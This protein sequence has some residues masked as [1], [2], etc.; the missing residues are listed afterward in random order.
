MIGRECLMK[1]LQALRVI[2]IAALL[3]SIVALIVAFQP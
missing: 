3:A 1:N 2:A